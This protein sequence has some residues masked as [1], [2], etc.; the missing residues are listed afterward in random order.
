MRTVISAL[1]LVFLSIS[2]ALAVDT[3]KT[4]SSGV[5]VSIF[6]GFCALIVIAQA[7]PAMMLL[8]GAIKAFAA[9]RAGEEVPATESV[10]SDT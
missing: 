5:L 10:R 1:A 7:V 3:A 6:L 8:L 9:R 4:Y 2:P